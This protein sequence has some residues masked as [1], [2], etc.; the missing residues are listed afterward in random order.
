MSYVYTGVYSGGNRLP[1]PPSPAVGAA[2][3]SEVAG[4]G[5]PYPPLQRLVPPPPSS[6][7]PPDLFPD[8]G[9]AAKK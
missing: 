3:F 9:S 4:T 5:N 2:A 7:G 8:A 6:G 1:L